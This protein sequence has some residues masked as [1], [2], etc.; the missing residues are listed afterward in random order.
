MRYTNTQ[1]FALFL[2]HLIVVTFSFA[3]LWPSY[4]DNSDIFQAIQNYN[5]ERVAN[6]VNEDKDNL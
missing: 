4:G 3:L 1:M 5:V 6:L 2:K